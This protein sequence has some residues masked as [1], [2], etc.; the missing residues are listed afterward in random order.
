MKLII[1]I[2]LATILIIYITKCIVKR[3]RRLTYQKASKK[4]E[5]IV[6]ELSDRK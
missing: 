5:G 4:W 3:F 2:L 6:K 1:I